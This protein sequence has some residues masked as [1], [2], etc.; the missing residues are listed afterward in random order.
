[1][2]KRKRTDPREEKILSY[3]RD[4]RNTYGESP[5]AARKLIR[6]RKAS[7]NRAY[8]RQLH[9]QLDPSDEPDD[10]GQRAELVK[11]KPWRKG[12]DTP[13]WQ[14]VQRRQQRRADA[15]GEEAPEPSEAQLEARRRG[16]DL[17]P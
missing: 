4:R 5:H 7:V 6:F 10:V 11:R 13:L 8:R 9:Q 3:L 14:V 1:M 16:R 17:P 12:E 15:Q 2:S